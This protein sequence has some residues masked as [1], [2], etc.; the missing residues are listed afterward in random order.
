[1]NKQN[2]QRIIYGVMIAVLALLL[3]LY[4]LKPNKLAEVLEPKTNFEVIDTYNGCA[5]VRYAAPNGANYH[6]FL[7]C[8]K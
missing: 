1:M 7:D 8:Q 6:Y 5:V 4:M 2:H 3:L